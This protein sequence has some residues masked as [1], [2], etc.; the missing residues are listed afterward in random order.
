MKFLTMADNSWDRNRPESVVS[1]SDKNTNNEALAPTA[2]ISSIDFERPQTWEKKVYLTIDIDW[3]HDDILA[4]TIQIVEKAGV[5]A[6]W[7]VTHETHVLS[8]LRSNPRFELGI[9]PNFNFLLQ[10]DARMGAT[11]EEVIEGI[12]E[13]VPEAKSVRSH[14]MTQSSVLLD[15]F[16]EKGL[17]HDCNHFIP[18]EVGLRLRPWKFWNGLTRVPYFWEDD[19]AFINKENTPFKRLVGCS[20]IRVF[21]FHPIHVFLNTESMDRYERTRDI[22]KCPKK[23][24]DHR[25][26]SSQGG[27]YRLCE[28]LESL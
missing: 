15:L 18:H 11:A 27:R 1:M 14:S 8:S 10:G 20:G 3:A 4:D 24:I 5:C 17:T 22:H 2:T 28:L 9:H 23:L 12:L 26:D 6:T 21:N 13:V 25:G 7:F 19:V 16:K